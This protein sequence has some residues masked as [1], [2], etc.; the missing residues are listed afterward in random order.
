MVEQG[1][2]EMSRILLVEDDP[3]VRAVLEAVLFDAGYHVIIATNVREGRTRLD[4]TE[5]D[6]LL[7]DGRLPD[8]TGITLADI[9]DARGIPVLI[10]TGYA[11]I[12]RQLADAAQTDKYR[13]LLKP[14]RP[15]EL[16]AAVEE[17]LNAKDLAARR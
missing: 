12:L 17:T 1:G 8:G 13:V 9:A 7:T 14:I 15:K 4:E 3:D 11:F 6:L 16:V 5:C 2:H 10:L